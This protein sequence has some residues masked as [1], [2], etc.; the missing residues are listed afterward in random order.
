MDERLKLKINGKPVVYENSVFRLCTGED[1]E[2]VDLKLKTAGTR[3]L[4]GGNM[5]VVLSSDESKF[6][7]RC[8]IMVIGLSY[9]VLAYPDFAEFPIVLK[10]TI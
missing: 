2:G 4:V 8:Y 3:T 9:K 6:C 5:T 1:C 7:L 10:N